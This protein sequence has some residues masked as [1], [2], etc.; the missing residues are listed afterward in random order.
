MKRSLLTVAV[1]VSL[2]SLVASA[3]A[4]QKN[5]NRDRDNNNNGQGSQSFVQNL[6]IGRKLGGQAGGI[7][8]MVSNFTKKNH[9]HDDKPKPQLDPNRPDDRV[10]VEPV[11]PVTPQGRPGFVWVGDHWERERAPKT[12]QMIVNPLPETLSPVVR[13]HRTTTAPIVRDHRTTTAPVVRD[14]RTGSP[15][16]GVTVTAT[17]GSSR[18][19]AITSSGFNPFA[20]ALNGLTT[21]GN[22]LGIGYGEVTS[23]APGSRD[24]RTPNPQPIVRD[25]R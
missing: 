15:S 6:G 12:P 2:F 18:D 9:K 19:N 22:K 24:H 4:G 3:S 8:N 5:R 11:A 25:H 10:P 17:P 21:V 23:G 20:S 1:I 7:A 13:D 16:G 14:H